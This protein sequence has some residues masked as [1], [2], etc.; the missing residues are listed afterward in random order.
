MCP[1]GVIVNASHGNG[2]VAVNGMSYSTR[3]SR[4]ANAA[5]VVVVGGDDFDNYDPPLEDAPRLA[6]L[7]RTGADTAA[8]T[9]LFFQQHWERKCFELAGS[10]Y[11]APAQ[12]V[13]DFLA[14]RKSENLPDS[15]FMGRLQSADLNEA[16]PDYVT[17]ALARVLKRHAERSMPGLI[18]EDTLLVG[19]ETRTSAPIRILRDESTL[20]STNVKHLYPI[21]EGAGYSGGIMTSSIDG[22][23]AAEAYIKRHEN[24]NQRH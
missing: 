21:G 23:R 17:S 15:L 8:L 4:F 6:A 13:P 24:A 18:A 7:E 22:V 20:E 19:A 2:E 12:R 3:A 16:L 9:G 5:F 11:A 1:G 14:G 10:D